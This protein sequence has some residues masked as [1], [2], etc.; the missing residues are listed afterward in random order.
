[1][2][3]NVASPAADVVWKRPTLKERA[4]VVALWWLFAVVIS[5]A[6]LT[7]H[8]TD[9]D[10]WFQLATC[11]VV[12]TAWGLITPLVM[13]LGGALVGG[14]ERGWLLVLVLGAVATAIAI[15]SLRAVFHN[16]GHRPEDRHALAW[17]VGHVLSTSYV[18][19]VLFA[20]VA[21]LGAARKAVAAAADQRAAAAA[22][23]AAAA[24]LERDAAALEARL[25][26]AQLQ[27][28]RMQINPHFLFN[29]LNS[30][31][32]LVERS[33]RQTRSVIARL[34]E[35]LR[36]ALHAEPVVTLDQ[37][38]R[39]VQGYLDIMKVRFEGQMAVDWTI[40]TGLG[41]A[42]IPAFLLQPLVEN[43]CEHGVAKVEGDKKIAVDVRQDG[44]M[45]QVEIRDN[46]PGP[47]DTFNGLARAIHGSGI[48]LSATRA[49]LR[50]HYGER[51]KLDLRRD[52]GGGTLACVRWP[53]QREPSE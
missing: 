1:M 14:R 29:T 52:E 38:L 30:I 36:Y 41:M 11:L 48:G 50:A 5:G 46:G 21:A 23:E 12:H 42:T 18:D 8:Q 34:S 3:A 53:A 22:S 16:L 25:G 10:A 40:E 51:A 33:P 19:L 13:R 26:D 6:A 4:L 24:R 44:D 2:V 43:A 35:L 20:A 37:E 49:R 28:L 47:D 27:A 45:L 15:S 31:S 7:G 32:S 17:L 9:G 39:S